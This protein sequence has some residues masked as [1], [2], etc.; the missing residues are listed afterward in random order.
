MGNVISIKHLNTHNQHRLRRFACVAQKTARMPEKYRRLRCC[1]KN[2]LQAI[3]TLTRSILEVEKR[4][5]QRFST[6]K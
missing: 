2:C 4:P 5:N 6:L 1:A 3:S